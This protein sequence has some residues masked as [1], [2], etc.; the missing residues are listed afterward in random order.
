MFDVNL[1]ANF[2]GTRCQGDVC[3]AFQIL[4]LVVFS[5]VIYSIYQCTT[6]VIY[7]QENIWSVN[8]GVFG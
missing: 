5:S 4:Y 3:Q 1:L 7:I 2:I 6:T 8:L